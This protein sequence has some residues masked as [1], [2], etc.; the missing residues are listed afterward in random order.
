MAG[1]FTFPTPMELMLIEQDKLA[2]LTLDD[3]IFK[4]F[5]VVTKNA[6]R[7]RFEQKDNYF[8][9]QQFRGIGGEPNRVA[10]VGAKSFEYRPGAY[11][12]FISVDEEELM[13]RRNYGSYNGFISLD[14]LVLDIQD[15][16]LQRRLDRIRWILWQL[17]T[18]GSFYVAAPST[19]G[20]VTLGNA[21]H[22][23]AYNTISALGQFGMQATV[24]A[25]PWSDKVNSSPIQNFRDVQL[26]GRGRTTSFNNN[27]VAMM[28]QVTANNLVTNRNPNDLGGKRANNF[29]STLTSIGDVNAIQLDSQLP[30][31][32]VYDEGYYDTNST[33]TP[34]IPNNTVIVIGMRPGMVLGEYEMTRNVNNENMAPGAYTFINDS[35][36]VIGARRVPRSIEI[37]D[38]HNGGPIIWYPS[39][40]VRMYV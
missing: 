18:T 21:V 19:T 32:V 13:D 27:A 8:G 40:I 23:D 9:L 39:A 35:A 3:P 6:V 25:T 2:T 7:I 10:R 1:T 15:Q 5:P 26:F 29:N 20:N 4:W 31:I 22:T 30:K 16:L 36:K 33:F 37:H 17:L 28:N 14:D 34:W 24:V 12:E 38:G 11:G